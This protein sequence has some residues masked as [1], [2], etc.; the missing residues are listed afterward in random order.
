MDK[1]AD[2]G[3]GEVVT[4]AIS[5]TVRVPA[6][7][8]A[9]GHYTVALIT[10]DNGRDHNRPNTLGPLGLASLESA[11]SAAVEAR[12]DAIAVTGKPFIFAAGADLSQVGSVADRATA[13]EFVAFGHRVFGRLR[14]APMPTFAF[15][16]GL[17][18]G[19]GMELAL[20]CDYRTL[21]SNAAGMSQPEVFL[22]ILPGWGGTQLLPRIAG[23]EN[24][25]T[26]IIENALNQ[27]RMLKPK[28]ALRLGA[29]DVV[30]DAADY[31]EQSFAWL[32]GVLDGSIAV[33]RK[34]FAGATDEE[35]AAALERGKIIADMRTH[36]ASPAAYRALE[37][38]ELA[39]NS[40]LS[41]GLAAERAALVDLIMS[42]EFRAGVYSFNLVQKRAKRPVGAPD[43]KLARKVTKVG[44]IGAGLM[45]GQLA[46]LFARNL[47]VPVVMTD[48]DQARLD[49]GLG[50]VKRDI[51]GLASKKRISPDEANRLTAL[52]S[53]SLD[54]AAFSDAEFVVEAVFE[55][56]G[57]KKQ[58]FAELEKYVR[59]DA[60]LATNTSS[61]SV[62]G[63]AADL[64]HPERVVGFHFFNPVAVMPL[65]EI[66]K[67]EKTDDATL[68]TAFA[69]A[70]R[71]RKGPILVKDAPGFVMNRLLVRFLAE[72]QAAVDEGTPADVADRATAP[73]G[74]PMSPMML[75]QLTGPAVGLHVQET[76]HDAF[77][78]RFPVSANLARIVQAG[79]KILVGW[80]DEG[81]Q[82]VAPEIVALFQQGDSPSTGE[83]V[84]DRA[85]TAVAQEARFM[86]DEGVVADSAD[87]DLAMI[88]GA[89]WPFWLGGITPYLDRSGISERAT[90]RRFA[91]PG[92]ATLPA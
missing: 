44:V 49:K 81:N 84:L 40:D 31:L 35:W 6:K 92:V 66:I 28:D 22:G 45:A 30:L 89:G 1:P 16:N 26:I 75:T 15:V 48:V 87:I 76:L 9:G 2:S 7:G 65:L 52:V 62:S 79:E 80:D 64:E 14:E 85:L 3:R 74:L 18:L 21:A 19:G 70:Q 4:H 54:Y 67:A 50:A 83:Q 34:D 51:A 63:M 23:P 38:I 91:A 17:A 5:R 20:H 69:V 11:I 12:P 37:M 78:D 25:V 86:L 60:V 71:L 56:I 33:Q 46:L 53:G 73:L 59:P 24:A 27:N 41:T 88:T 61:L 47:H 43:P 72:V 32:A 58:V 29:V 8:A 82:I 36:G 42:Q 77:G 90:G 68:A 39:K 57:V 55:E 13:E 10:L